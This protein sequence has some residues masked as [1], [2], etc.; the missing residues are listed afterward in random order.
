MPRSDLRPGHCKG[1]MQNVSTCRASLTYVSL[2]IYEQL[3][4]IGSRLWILKVSIMVTYL[5]NSLTSG[6]NGSSE[7]GLGF[8]FSFIH[9]TGRPSQVSPLKNIVKI[10]LLEITI[11]AP[12]LMFGL[13]LCLV[14]LAI[15]CFFRLQPVQLARSRQ[16]S[17]ISLVPAPFPPLK[18]ETL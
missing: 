15:P 2:N 17:A 13:S 1:S 4:K 7:S 16:V 14:G 3:A 9:E 8:R 11:E 10:P 18:P 12:F 6:K 5:Q